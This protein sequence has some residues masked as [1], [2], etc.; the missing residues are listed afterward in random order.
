MNIYIDGKLDRSNDI[1][2]FNIVDE[3]NQ[4]W[5]GRHYSRY[6]NGCIDEVR[7]YERAVSYNEIQGLYYQESEA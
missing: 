6:F 1:A 7:I 4:M 2:P 5:I 3:N